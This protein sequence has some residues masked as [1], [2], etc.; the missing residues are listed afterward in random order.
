MPAQ[1]D[2]AHADAVAA[3][4]REALTH[5]RA[6]LEARV[7]LVGGSHPDVADAQRSAASPAAHARCPAVPCS[8]PEAPG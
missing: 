6:C 8:R 1:A 4:H 3:E 7:A 5:L 2:G